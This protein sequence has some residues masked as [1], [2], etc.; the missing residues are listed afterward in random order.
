MPVKISVLAV[1]FVL[2]LHISP[3]KVILRL[4]SPY[5][6]DVACVRGGLGKRCASNLVWVTSVCALAWSRYR[7]DVSRLSSTLRYGRALLGH[8]EDIA[9]AFSTRLSHGERGCFGR[10]SM[11][12]DDEYTLC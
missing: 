8:I 10:I 2:C 11:D 6:W 9:S 1:S 12:I 4:N 7:L 5:S 3:L